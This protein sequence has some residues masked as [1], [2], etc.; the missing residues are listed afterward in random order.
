MDLFELVQNR[1]ISKKVSICMH[2]I[3]MIGCWSLW[4]LRGCDGGGGHA[5]INMQSHFQNLN[6][7]V[8]QSQCFNYSF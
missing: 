4:F 2:S 7:F 3:N 8:N 6:Y 1:E 5:D